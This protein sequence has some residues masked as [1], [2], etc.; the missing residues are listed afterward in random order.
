MTHHQARDIRWA[1]ILS[2][3]GLVAVAAG[4][5]SRDLVAQ[6]ATMADREAVRRAVLD[7][8]EGF[9]EGDS[10]KLARSVR[11][12]VYKY[13]FFKARDS[14]TYAGMQMTWQ[15]FFNYARGVKQNN[16]QAPPTAPKRIELYDV[17]DQTASAKLTASWGTD[18]LLLA[19][20]NGKWMISHV[21]WQ[22]PVPAPPPTGGGPD[23]GGGD[24]VESAVEP[25]EPDLLATDNVFRGTFA[26]D[27]RTFLFFRKVG[28][29]RDAEEYR[30][31]ESRLVNGR[32]SAPTR[33]SLGGEYSD[34]YP[35]ISP[36]GRRM[37]F[38]S[39]RPVPGDTSRHPNAHLWYV[40]RSGDGWG[41]PVFMAKASI[42]GYYN[43]GPQFLSDGSVHWNATTPDWRSQKTY[44]TRWGGRE[45]SAPQVFELADRW[46]NWKPDAGGS[47]ARLAADRSFAILE[48][49]HTVGGRRIPPDLYVSFRRGEEWTEPRPLGGGVNTAATE[50]FVTISPDNRYLYFVRDFSGFYRA[51]LDRVLPVWR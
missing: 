14:T 24:G 42:L 19:K 2:C 13:G 22:G 26:P 43:S 45:Y 48:V 15:G 6:A 32:W 1:R 36:D 10:T 21:M 37:V 23:D 40:D 25:F 35:T 30:I 20:Y 46:R 28:S 31:L 3:A 11:P 8:V 16:R 17:Q 9:Y 39:Y 34:L 41:T 44:I 38:S 12:E 47:L 4:T 29:N 5:I 33:V 51:P 7:Y 49:A 18:Y 50:N 27:G